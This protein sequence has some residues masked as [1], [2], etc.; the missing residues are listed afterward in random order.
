[1]EVLGFARDG[2]RVERIVD[3]G[4][5]SG[6]IA[7]ALAVNLP[8]ARVLAIDRSLDA[9][10][11]AEENVQRHRVADRVELLLGDLLAGLEGEH[12]VVVAN[13]PYVPSDQI[14]TL[15]RQVRDWEPRIALDG[16]P[17]G[18]DPH[19]RLLTQLPGR[20]RDG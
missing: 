14:A 19:R 4:T 1:E 9:I 20:L 8:D 7:V 17:D 11:I 3:V 5:G 13:P 16:G 2:N 12:D 10:K 15:Q 18:L 6:A